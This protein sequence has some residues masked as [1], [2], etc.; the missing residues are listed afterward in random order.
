MN[1]VLEIVRRPVKAF[2]DSVSYTKIAL[3]SPRDFSDNLAKED[4]EHFFRAWS[5]AFWMAGL[6]LGALGT[7]IALK[8][9]AEKYPEFNPFP[10]INI[11]IYTVSGMANSILIGIV[12]IIPMTMVFSTF[13]SILKKDNPLRRGL[14]SPPALF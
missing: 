14:F 13:L 3:F 5:S 9:A 4:N 8:G 12:L 7:G 6:Y 2:W 1:I 11:E 10:G